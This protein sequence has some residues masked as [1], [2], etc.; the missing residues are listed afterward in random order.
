LNRRNDPTRRLPSKLSERRQGSDF[1]AGVLEEPKILFGKR[2][3]HIDPK[4][5]LSLFGPY[6]EEGQQEPAYSSIIVGI[7]GPAAML[8]DAATWLEA[9]RGPIH[10]NGSQPFMAP[11]FPGF[12][13]DSPFRC[14]LKFGEPWTQAI[15]QSELS[16]SLN[17]SIA[18]VR[19]KKVV[20]AY[21]AA[22]R[23]LK[24]R[25]PQPNV[26]LCCMPEEV[27]KACTA[28]YLP[29]I[30]VRR[31]KITRAESRVQHERAKGQL[32]LFD[33]HSIVPLQKEAPE[34]VGY[35]NLRRGLKAEAMPIGIP[36]QLIQPRTLDVRDI[37]GSVQ[38]RKVQD[39]ATRAWNLMTGLYHKAG[40]SPWRLDD[41]PSDVCFVGV[42]FYRETMEENPYL[43]TCMAQAFTSAGD[44][45]VLRGNSFEWNESERGR[46][47]HL[48]HSSAASLIRAVVDKYMSQNKK[49]PPARIVLHKSSK[50]SE[51][52][53]AGFRKG[54]EGVP[55]QDFVAFGRRGVQFYRQGSYPPLRG[56]YVKFSEK[57][58]GLYTDGYIPFLKTY[59]G[60]RAP[61]PLE[62]IEHYGDSPWNRVLREILALTKM[63]WNTASFSCTDPITIA[64]SRRVGEVLAELPEGVE[65]RQE[66]RYYM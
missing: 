43:K 35:R 21:T 66:Y 40:G 45:Y 24:D 11:H 31:P 5:G 55:E 2:Q 12:S 4:T 62:I 16:Q 49:Q 61:R 46:S 65:P 26:I 37:G 53:L 51:E 60:P 54:C 58:F 10:N 36:I 22:M 19:L 20:E 18:E 64:F 23:V 38:N 44:G 15:S 42:S 32:F 7:V 34:I 47:P 30:R 27:L 8:G 41:I 9:C 25:N 57:E 50:F 3:L 1:S 63:N 17:E 6:C 48:T 33:L 13:K 28:M 56:T 59:P 52:E 39:A 14:E 29:S